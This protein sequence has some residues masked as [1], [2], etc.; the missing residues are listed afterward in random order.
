MEVQRQF[1]LSL[2]MDT[3]QEEMFLLYRDGIAR[4]AL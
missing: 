4:N 3:G 2:P 1:M